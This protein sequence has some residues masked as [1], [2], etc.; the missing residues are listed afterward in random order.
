MHHFIFLKASSCEM[1]TYMFHDYENTPDVFVINKVLPFSGKFNRLIGDAA[2]RF[3][4]SRIFQAAYTL[5][6]FVLNPL[7]NVPVEKDSFYLLFLNIPSREFTA[8][9]LK[10]FLKKHPNCTPVMLFIDPID[11]Y[12]S[13]YAHNLTKQIPQFLCMTYDPSDAQKY[14]YYH[15]M[16]IYSKYSLKETTPLYDIYFS[17]TGMN[18]LESVQAVTTHFLENQVNANII[19][20]GEPAHEQYIKEHTNGIHFLKSRKTYMDVLED[21]SQSNCI[22]EILQEGHSGTT[23]RYY[24]AICYNK[25]LLTNNK[26][27]VN[28]PFYNP[29]YMK[30]FEKPED[31][32]C[33]WLKKR[34]PVSYG[35]DNRFS[36]INLLEEIITLNSNS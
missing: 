1:T 28:L 3:M 16:C 10:H 22:L 20:A 17:F 19:I 11:N 2:T 12:M 25:K 34:E 21:V 18:R 4:N 26:N 35:Y 24:E 7:K 6:L 9:Y 13:A 23:L 5:F 36:P 27:I 14:G 30:I 15:T 32:D 31:I 8:N 29:N 33:D